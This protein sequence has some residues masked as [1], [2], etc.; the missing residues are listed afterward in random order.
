MK[1][2]TERDVGRIT[3]DETPKLALGAMKASD[4]TAMF[5][6]RTTAE[7]RIE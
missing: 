7:A 1:I 6:T 4:V 3:L 2:G 5:K